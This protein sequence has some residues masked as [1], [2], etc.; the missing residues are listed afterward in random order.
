MIDIKQIIT[1]LGINWSV[2]YEVG[3][4]KPEESHIKNFSYEKLILTE[5][6]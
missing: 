1:E 3:V 6:C 4:W 2:V 5:R